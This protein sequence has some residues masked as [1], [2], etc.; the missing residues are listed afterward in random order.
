LSAYKPSTSKQ[1]EEWRFKFDDVFGQP[2]T[3]FEGYT[4]HFTK[5]LKA[6]YESFSEVVTVCKAAG[7]KTVTSTRMNTTD[8]NIVLA[9]NY[10]DD[11][12]AQK[13]IK[14]GVT[15]FTKDLFTY[16]IFRGFLD[17]QGDEFKIKAP[18]ADNTPS[19]GKKKRGRKST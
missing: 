12:E 14:D 13:L 2:Q 3:P 16:S 15:C 8:D 4:I 18:D 11:P 19:K 1:E 17:L 9:N 6:I 7:A 10:D 5:N